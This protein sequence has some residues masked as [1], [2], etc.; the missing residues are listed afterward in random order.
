MQPQA[1]GPVGADAK[2]PDAH[3]PHAIRVRFH[4]DGDW[5]AIG[6]L[7][8][9]QHLD[10]QGRHQLPANPGHQR[11]PPN[12]AVAISTCRSDE[13]DSPRLRLEPGEIA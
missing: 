8:H 13:A 2:G 4:H 9:A 1:T 3:G 7:G 11:Y 12:D 6:G 5:R 10:R